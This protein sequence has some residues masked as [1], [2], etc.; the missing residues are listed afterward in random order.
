MKKILLLGFIALTYFSC[1]KSGDVIPNV[2][3]NFQ[4]PL[5]DPRLSP[6]NVPGGAVLINGYGVAGLILYHEAD[7]SYAAYDRCSTYMP[8]NHCAV[9]LDAGNF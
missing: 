4:A 7:N 2:A 5:T 6:L 8:Q 9:T 1:G 3:F